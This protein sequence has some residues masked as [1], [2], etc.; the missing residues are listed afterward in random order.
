[1][2]PSSTALEKSANLNNSGMLV[3]GGG[4]GDDDEEE[5]EEDGEAPEGPLFLSPPPPP[6]P[7]S[8]RPRC[9]WP[10]WML[11]P[12]LLLFCL[13]PP[14]LL[15]LCLSLSILLLLLRLVMLLVPIIPHPQPWSTAGVSIAAGLAD[16]YLSTGGGGRASP[17]GS[18]GL[19]ASV[20]AL[21]V[22]G[23]ETTRFDGL[24]S[25]WSIPRSCRNRVPSSV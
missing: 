16:W 5:E 17:G 25:L 3:G 14:F 8:L 2:A 13:P 9:V 23:M 7:L 18:P 1:M 21:R 22:A 4:R 24:R 10:L 11:S 12:F 19:G 6:P 20:G 15:P